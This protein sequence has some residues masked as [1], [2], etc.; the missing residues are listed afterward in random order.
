MDKQ[1]ADAIVQAILLPDLDAQEQI[2]KK[3]EREAVQLLRKRRIALI[4][5][6]GCAVGAIA[7]WICGIRVDEGVIYGGLTASALGWLFSARPSAG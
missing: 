1:Q 6:A 4:T 7:A 2:R 3:R 5:L